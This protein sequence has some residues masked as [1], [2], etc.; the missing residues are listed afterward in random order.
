[1]ENGLLTIFLL[2]L[3]VLIEIKGP[4]AHI[5]LIEPIAQ[6]ERMRAIEA[7]SQPFFCI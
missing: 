6:F 4:F 5:V 3:P 7:Q 1:M 2:T